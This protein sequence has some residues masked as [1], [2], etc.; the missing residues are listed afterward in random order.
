MLKLLLTS[1]FALFVTLSV[2]GMTQQFQQNGVSLADEEGDLN[3]QP[4]PP[5]A[6]E[7]VS[8]YV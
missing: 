6:P 2:V 4:L 7:I 5:I 3:P 1:F 8:E